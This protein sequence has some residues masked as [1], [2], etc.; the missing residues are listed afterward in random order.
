MARLTQGRVV[1]GSSSINGLMYVRGNRRDFDHWASLGN[2]GWD[3]RSVLP[4][5]IKAE[6]YYGGFLGENGKLLLLFCLFFFLGG[7]EGWSIV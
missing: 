6:N 5:F 3:Y 4:Y 1:G 2:A 7:G